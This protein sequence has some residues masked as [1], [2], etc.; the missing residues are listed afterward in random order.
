MK[1]V[2][3]CRRLLSPGAASAFLLVLATALGAHAASTR[4]VGTVKSLSGNSIVVTT[5]AGGESTL[6]LTA[7]THILKVLPGQ[8][9]KDAAPVQASEIKVG[10]RILA[11]GEPGEGN[12]T[13]ASTVVVMKQ[14]DIAEKQREE[15]DQW[16]R[17]VGGIAKEVNA[18]AGTVTI[19]NGLS[20]GAKPILIHASS[21]TA[22]RRYSPDSVKFDDAKPGTLDEIK[23]GDQVRARGQKSADGTEFEA[24]AIVSGTFR[25]IAGTVISADAAGGN[26][27]VMD[28]AA[29]KPVTLKVTADSQMRQL[30]EPVAERL[31]MRLKGAPPGNGGPN[32]AGAGSGGAVSARAQGEAS[33]GGSNPGQGQA[34][35]AAAGASGPRPG[36][37]RAF[38]AAGGPPDFQ[39]ILS[40]MPGV[41]LSDLHKGEAVMVVATSGTTTTAPTTITLLSGVEPILAAAPSG[42]AAATMLSPWNL[43]A[44]SGGE[45]AP[46]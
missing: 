19:A 21:S 15:G 46:E 11:A 34:G 10:D 36:G 22:I 25:E 3:T 45:A 9:L 4:V 41:S 8:T 18:A 33:G 40:R 13:T 5:D 14:S 1:R 30:P 23:P 6:N 29:K 35:E 42:A 37:P 28:L 7:T 44:P 38:G 20:A 26:L 32:P 17:G 43:G 24:Q 2:E 16:R 39:Q 12:Q 31:A 27:T